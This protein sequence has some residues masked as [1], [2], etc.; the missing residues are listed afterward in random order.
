MQLSELT[1]QEFQQ[2]DAEAFQEQVQVLH[3][4]QAADFLHLYNEKDVKIRNKRKWI[5]GGFYTNRFFIVKFL[6]G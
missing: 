5:N 2:A 1:V 3:A 4:L 6:Y